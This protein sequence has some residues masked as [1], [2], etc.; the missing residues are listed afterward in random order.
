MTS[1]IDKLH[2]DRHRDLY[3]VT[4]L[5]ILSYLND[6]MVADHHLLYELSWSREW[7]SGW[8]DQGMTVRVL[9]EDVNDENDPCSKNSGLPLCERRAEVQ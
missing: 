3:S 2:L 9:N 8:N 6:A 7:E 5:E 4:P 1:Y